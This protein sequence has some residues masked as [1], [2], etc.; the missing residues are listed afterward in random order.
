MC[1]RAFPPSFQRS[2]A[3]RIFATAYGA[4]VYRQVRPPTGVGAEDQAIGSDF[5]ADGGTPSQS[6]S[7]S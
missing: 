2:D 5:Q 1:A 3:R 7:F 4:I 6:A